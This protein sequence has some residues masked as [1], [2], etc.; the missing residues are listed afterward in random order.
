[1]DGVRVDN[2]DNFRSARG[3]GGL[4]SSSLADILTGD[5]ERVEVI[6]GGAASTLYGS[7][8]ANGVI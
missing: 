7:D 4:V 5:I 8:A 1:V 3:S 6:K 2:Q